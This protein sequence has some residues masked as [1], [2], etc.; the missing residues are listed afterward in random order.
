MSKVT[1]THRLGQAHGGYTEHISTALKEV[2]MLHK[3]ALW[4]PRDEC[5]NTF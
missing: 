1:E 5:K 3:Y 2:Q 4:L